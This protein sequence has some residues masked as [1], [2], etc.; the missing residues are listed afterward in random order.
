MS[1]AFKIKNQGFTLIEMMVVVAIMIIITA[2][3]LAN[4]PGFRART[5][6][7][8]VAQ[9]VAITIR[10]AQE[11]AVG[12]RNTGQ[13]PFPSFGVYFAPI[14][15][16]PL[17]TFF[18]YGDQGSPIA[19]YPSGYKATNNYQAAL[20]PQFSFPGT[21]AIT[22]IFYC[23]VG[24]TGESCLDISSKGNSI[25]FARPDPDALF[26]SGTQKMVASYYKIQITNS[27]SNESRCVS[28][29][30]TGYIYAPIC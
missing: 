6:L 18:I 8:L 1:P 4:F 2:V 27:L 22:H 15:S 14:T 28:V 21:V 3:V 26:Y 12:T 11:Y 19:Q 29:W 10:Q 30:Q 16:G 17:T 13:F 23:L 25:L 5:S 7:D 24:G 20:D 9:E